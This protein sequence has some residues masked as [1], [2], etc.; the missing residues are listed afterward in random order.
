[1]KSISKKSI[2]FFH[3][4]KILIL[5]LSVLN[6]MSN[7]AQKHEM[8]VV[9]PSVWTIGFASTI[10]ESPTNWY[11]ATVP[12]AV[13]LDLAKALHYG[14]YYYAEN[15]KDYGW[16][17]DQFFTYRTTFAKPILAENQKCFFVSKGIDYEFEITLN[18]EKLFYQEGM[19][20]PVKLDLTSKLK[21]QN[22]LFVKIFPIPKLHKQPADRTQAAQSVKPAVS[23]G[24]D[25]HPRLVPVGIW[26]ET[27]L[28]VQNQSE[29]TDIDFSYTLDKE[30]KKAI[31][32]TRVE[33]KS[34][35]IAGIKLS[36]WMQMQE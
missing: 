8:Q 9:S 17:E 33:G 23:Y 16:M 1:M 3:S 26:D 24:W 6:I 29:I 5:I 21:D 13:Q 10:N 36:F 25:W 32:K 22:E 14:T 20:T 19:F 2:S 7:K 15:W 18:G 4:M 30:L 27:G 11:S 35:S 28:L 31:I 34:F 12:S